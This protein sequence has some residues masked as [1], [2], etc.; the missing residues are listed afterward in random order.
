MIHAA[1]L[2]PLL[3]LV[4]FSVL[5]L[6]GKRIG[7]PLSGWVATL[8]VGGSCVATLVTFAGLVGRSADHRAFTQLIFEWLPVGGLKINAAIL[9]DPLS[10]TMA[11]FVTGVG[12]LIHLY[13]IGYMKGD[14]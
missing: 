2:I 12:T 6:A 14:S 1:F 9:V 8:A 7:A 5:V 13:A 10:M 4:G 11:L 3:P